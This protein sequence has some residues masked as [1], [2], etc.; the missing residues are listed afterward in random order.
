M[1]NILCSQAKISSSPVPFVGLYIAS[2]S[3]VC[4]LLILCDLFFSIRRKRPY[5]PCKFFSLNSTTLTLLAIASKLPVD[6]T[7]YMPSATDQL[8][9]LV[10]TSI[11][12]VSMAFMMPSLGINRRSENITNMISLSLFVVTTVFSTT[13][14]NNRKVYLV[15]EIRDSFRRVE[16]LI[17]KVREWYIE[18]SINNPQFE[19]CKDVFAMTSSGIICIIC[20]AILSQAAV[21]S[22]VLH[23]LEFC[24]EQVSDYRWS[25]PMILVTQIITVLIASLATTCRW[26]MML[27]HAEIIDSRSKQSTNEIDILTFRLLRLQG[28]IRIKYLSLRLIQAIKSLIYYFVYFTI[29]WVPFVLYV[30]VITYVTDKRREGMQVRTGIFW[31]KRKIQRICEKDMHNLMDEI[32]CRCIKIGLDFEVLEGLELT[33]LSRFIQ[34]GTQFSGGSYKVSCLTVVILARFIVVSMPSTRTKPL[35]QALDEIYEMLY[36]VDKK[37]NSADATDEMKRNL[38]GVIMHETI[39]DIFT[40]DEMSLI[41]YRD[42]MQKMKNEFSF[43]DEKYSLVRKEGSIIMKY[44]EEDALATDDCVGIQRKL[45][46]LFIVMLHFI[47]RQL[48]S[49]V[50]KDVNESPIEEHEE[51]A[52][53]VFKLVCKFK[54][55]GDIVPI[56]QNMEENVS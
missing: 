32:Y 39:K 56:F 20:L 55:L 50:A 5:L 8:S 40:G 35:I 34:V 31:L 11:V 24:S 52:L 33:S 19:L 16:S 18:S 36:Y 48:P 51:R 23:K 25:I 37:T 1:D 41:N 42:P 13:L 54:F 7:T 4:L 12:C 3:L 26:F 29:V 46:Q 15:Q 45:E 27:Y 49:V 10:G 21:R 2:A 43:L 14:A 44:L 30:P 9:K 28:R 53:V 6:L 22:L 47:L 17:D 38:T